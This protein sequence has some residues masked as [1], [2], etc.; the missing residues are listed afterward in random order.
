M[1]IKSDII[2]RYTDIKKNRQCITSYIKHLAVSGLLNVSARIKSS[3]K[4]IGKSFEMPNVSYTQPLAATLLTTVLKFNRQTNERTSQRFGK[5]KRGATPS[6]S[7]RTVA[8]HLLL[9]QPHQ[10]TIIITKC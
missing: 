9:P 5:I 2:D 6:T 8:P 4:L 1:F 3:Y 7:Q 10:K